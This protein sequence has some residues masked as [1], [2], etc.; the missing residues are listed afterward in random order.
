MTGPGTN[1]TLVRIGAGSAMLGAVATVG[2]Y[3]LRPATEYGAGT[4][5]VLEVFAANPTRFEVHT[6]GVSAALLLVLGGLVGLHEALGDEPRPAALGRLG[7][8]A[9]VVATGLGL[10]GPVL[11]GTVLVTLAEAWAAAPAGEQTAARRVAEA[12]LVLNVV[13]VTR[14]FAVLFLAFL[15][16]GAG[17][18]AHS[19]Y[20]RWLGW[21]GTGLGGLAVAA[22]IVMAV[23]GIPVMA[24]VLVTGVLLTL[25]MAWLFATG[26]FLWRHW[27]S[28]GGTA[29]G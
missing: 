18:W 25:L 6:L 15:L 22:G 11:D 2:F 14:I 20:P 28:P 21:A 4:R 23:Q 1:L 12:S 16:F 9:A 7:L 19:A 13:L 27:A 8:T 17:V 10:L 26:A 24:V 5:T 3:F 29:H